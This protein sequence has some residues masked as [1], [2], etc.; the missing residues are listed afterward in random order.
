MN[1]ESSIPHDKYKVEN[2]SNYIL[3]FNEFNPSS[4]SE[5]DNLYVVAKVSNS[6]IENDEYFTD[7]SN[8]LDNEFYINLYN[9]FRLYDIRDF[10]PS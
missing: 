8:S 2:S 9:Y 10:D 6:M 3:C 5:K 4:A 1:E 7:L